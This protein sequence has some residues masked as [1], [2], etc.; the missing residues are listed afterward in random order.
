ME[1]GVMKIVWLINILQDNNVHNV[2]LFWENKEW[3]SANGQWKKCEESLPPKKK[4][5]NLEDN[6][7]AHQKFQESLPFEKQAQILEDNAVAHKKYQES[8]PLEKKAQILEDN[9]A[10]HQKFQESLPFEKKA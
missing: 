7:V 4:A 9:A 6:A 1:R 3:G 2:L 8:L 5:Q 10:A